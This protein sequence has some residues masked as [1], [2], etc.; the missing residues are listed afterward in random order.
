MEN[1]PNPKR[2]VTVQMM[3][4]L[5]SIDALGNKELNGNWDIG[6]KLI[7][8]QDCSSTQKAKSDQE[9]MHLTPSVKDSKS[10][11]KEEKNIV[12]HGCEDHRQPQNSHTNPKMSGQCVKSTEYRI[13]NCR[14]NSN[15]E[16]LTVLSAKSPS[17]SPS[18]TV[19]QNTDKEK[20]GNSTTKAL[21]KMTKSQS[22]TSETSA[23]KGTMQNQKPS[24][25]SPPNHSKSARASLEKDLSPSTNNTKKDISLLSESKDL[26]CTTS[27]AQE[28]TISSIQFEQLQVGSTTSALKNNCSRVTDEVHTTAETFQ[29]AHNDEKPLT[30]I[31]TPQPHEIKHA[32]VKEDNCVVDSTPPGISRETPSGHL[33]VSSRSNVTIPD[34]SSHSF[35]TEAIVEEAQM[36]GAALEEQKQVH[37]KLYCEASTMTSAVQFSNQPSMQRHDVEVQ[38]VAMV[39]SQSTATSP[40]LLPLQPHQR[41]IG[42]LPEET[43]SLGVV[44][45]VETTDRP[46]GA[47]SE[48]HM[49]TPTVVSSSTILL[50]KPT[51]SGTV[52]VHVD[53]DLQ[54]ELKLGAKP[55][56]PG[57][58]LPNAQRGF[59]PLH[60]V[61]QINIETCNQNKYSKEARCSL[62]SQGSPALSGTGP[63]NSASVQDKTSDHASQNLPK[64]LAKPPTSKSALSQSE[65]YPQAA[66]SSE[67]PPSDSTM[68]TPPTSSSTPQSRKQQAA[69][70]LK[71]EKEEQDDEKAAKETKKS[72]HDVV[73][74]EQGMTWE[75]YGASVDPESLGFAIQS[76]LQCKIIEHEKK[77]MVQTALR[78]S[79]SLPPSKKNKRRQVNISFRSMFQNIRRPNC[80]GRPSVLE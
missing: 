2:T 16:S 71:P 49:N 6:P 42:L 59:S 22:K 77:V 17:S 68:A 43:E 52:M 80:C 13:N 46:S 12:S 53:A 19:T 75:V 58:C 9:H 47:T 1:F 18:S 26:I 24:E 50:E 57:S 39:C 20:N 34:N 74:D 29:Q 79:L 25:A 8:N 10:H 65:F 27:I 51:Q 61:Y 37:C 4:Q 28:S 36:Q 73:W 30:N 45:G 5:A 41:L 70:K 76:H 11:T 60:P 21:E 15:S 66:T 63:Q 56:E 54:R 38:A 35:H 14:S 62:Q 48:I 55:K 78:K 64:E 33:L 7:L 72:V 69:S 40:S 3:Q 32:P 31:Q 44:F 23:I 67:K